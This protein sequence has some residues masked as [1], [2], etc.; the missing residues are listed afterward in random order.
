MDDTLPPALPGTNV[1]GL[2]E[3]FALTKFSYRLMIIL[4]FALGVLSPVASEIYGAGL[5]VEINDYLS[6]NTGMHLG[7][8][9]TLF[10][11]AI[12]AV[13]A[14]AY[15]WSLVALLRFKKYSIKLNLLTYFMLLLMFPF[16]PAS[17]NGGV[18]FG[19][20]SL[21]TV[22]SGAVIALAYWSPA[23]HWFS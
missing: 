19:L 18:S 11:L 5:P 8:A 20:D 12:V 17:V 9:E 14:V 15:L 22:L 16:F 21:S 1:T 10:V 7:G 13:L 2:V 6:Q 3:P 23:K 4:S